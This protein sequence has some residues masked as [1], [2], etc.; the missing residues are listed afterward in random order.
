MA[1]QPANAVARM[2]KFSVGPK[3]VSMKVTFS[4]SDEFDAFYSA[5]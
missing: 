2:F 3:N 4:C 1:R 5:A